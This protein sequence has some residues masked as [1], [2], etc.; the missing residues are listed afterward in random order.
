VTNKKSPRA[1]ERLAQLRFSV[2]GSLLASPPP[3]GRLRAEIKKLAAKEW[4]HPI[5]GEP[6]RF[7]CST[8]ERWYYKS[9]KDR[10]DPVGA[11]RRKLPGTAGQQTSMSDPVRQALLAQYAAYKSWSIKLHRD[12]LVAL[13]EKQPELRPIPSYPTIRRFFRARGLEKWKRL[14]SKQTEGAQRAE[15][16]L[17]K[18]EVRSYEAEYVGGLFH[19][20]GHPASRK[21][22]TRRGELE[23]PTLIGV[24]DDRSRLGC[25]LQWCLPEESADNVA[26]CLSQAFQKRGLPASLMTDGGGG[27]NADEIREGL[28]RL[29]ILREKTLPYSP[30]QN[31][32]IEILWAQVEGR[33]MA[34][35]ENVPG[36]TLDFLNEATQAWVEF[37]YNREVHDE[38]GQ[39]PVDRFLAG[40]SVL[41]QCPD[42]AT[43]RLAFTKVDRRTQ[44]RSDG[45]IVI[46]G[47]RFEIP[48]RYRHFRQVEIRYA[49]WDLSQVHLVDERT[50]QVLCRLQRQDKIQNASGL[51]RS[52]EPLTPELTVAPAKGL[53]PLLAKLLDRQTATGLP[54]AYLPKNDDDSEDDG[55]E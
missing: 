20:D 39:T 50:G 54:P 30:Y 35:L 52:L 38:T 19:C 45:T 5:T 48:N 36:L 32:K 18:R 26:H 24:L 17:S 10:H 55:G 22:L 43:L 47:R 53:P 14:T 11:L 25:H 12:N 51:R 41:R 37:E 6:I 9:I 4:R 2:I 34:M 13:G 21:V 40:P 1:H 42:S 44:R 49:G 31:G 27:M 28:N 16:R 15:A 8:I 3:K 33:L 46:Q 7:G 29:G 23:I